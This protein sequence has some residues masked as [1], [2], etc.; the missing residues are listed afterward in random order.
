MD[1]A[2]LVSTIRHS[3]YYAWNSLNKHGLVH[4]AGSL[5]AISESIS[6]HTKHDEAKLSAEDSMVGLENVSRSHEIVKRHFYQYNVNAL[7]KGTLETIKERLES[8]VVKAL[9]FN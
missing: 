9:E 4:L 5:E 1:M 2:G 3:P 6:V 8:E 7:T